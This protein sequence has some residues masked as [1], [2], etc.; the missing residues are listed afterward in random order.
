[1]SDLTIAEANEF[2]GD[3]IAYWLGNPFMSPDLLAA[4]VCHWLTI[5]ANESIVDPA[6]CAAECKP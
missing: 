2:V 1:M 4:K 6:D 3:D 5:A